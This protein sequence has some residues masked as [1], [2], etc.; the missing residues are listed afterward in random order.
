MLGSKEAKPKNI[1]C[2][3]VLINARKQQSNNLF[4]F[5]LFFGHMQMRTGTWKRQRFEDLIYYS[6]T[7]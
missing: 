6:K 2:Q 7:Q 1:G 5:N 3:R 4:L